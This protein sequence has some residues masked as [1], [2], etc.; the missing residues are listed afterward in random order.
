MVFLN[1]YSSLYSLKFITTLNYKILRLP[2]THTVYINLW[3]LK[4]NH[5]MF[6]LVQCAVWC[7]CA[8]GANSH[9]CTTGKSFV[10]TLDY[11]LIL[12][13][14]N[15]QQERTSTTMILTEI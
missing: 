3:N 15:C 6:G 9:F 14:I 7:D 5:I 2:E 1:T 11:V 4:F 12:I 10:Y 13:W 8:D